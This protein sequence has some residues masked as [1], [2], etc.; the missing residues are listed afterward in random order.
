[1]EH[2]FDKEKANIGPLHSSIDKSVHFLL[3]LLK[4]LVYISPSCMYLHLLKILP[5]I[6][7]FLEA[8]RRLKEEILFVFAV[9]FHDIGINFGRLLLK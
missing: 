5:K 8:P 2:A 7:N 9:F 3:W 6:F 4:T 1:M